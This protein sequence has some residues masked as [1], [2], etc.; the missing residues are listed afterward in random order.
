MRAVAPQIMCRSISKVGVRI[1]TPRRT[2]LRI[3]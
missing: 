3:A 2:S 1:G